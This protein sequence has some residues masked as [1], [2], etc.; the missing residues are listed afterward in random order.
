MVNQNNQISIAV[1]GQ[2]KLVDC[3]T[4]IAGL[5]E[6]LEIK[7]PAIAVELNASITT[8]DSY[9]ATILKDGDVVEIVSLVGGG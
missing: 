1:N 6:I 3:Q 2:T 5:L 9:S 4:N 7:H 8:Q